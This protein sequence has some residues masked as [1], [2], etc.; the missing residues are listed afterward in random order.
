MARAE[1]RHHDDKHKRRTARRHSWFTLVRIPHTMASPRE[2]GILAATPKRCSCLCC[3]NARRF[4]GASLPER[5]A[6]QRE[7]WS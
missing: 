2:V 4:Y 6:N 3:G 5:R 7:R 1:N